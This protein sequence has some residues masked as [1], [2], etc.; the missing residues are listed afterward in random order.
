MEYNIEYRH[1]GVYL[2]RKKRDE[3]M[4]NDTRFENFANVEYDAV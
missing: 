2:F 1:N 4:Q 3:A